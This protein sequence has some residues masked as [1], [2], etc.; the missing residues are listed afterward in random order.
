MSREPFWT[1]FS[2]FLKI[3]KLVRFFFL[4]FQSQQNST[5]ITCEYGG[6]FV[7]HCCRCENMTDVHFQHVAQR[8]SQE[9]GETMDYEGTNVTRRRGIC[10]F[11]PCELWCMRRVTT[12]WLSNSLY[13]RKWEWDMHRAKVAY[14]V[15][16][17]FSFSASSTIFSH[18]LW[19]IVSRARLSS[20]VMSH[21]HWT[22]AALG[23]FAT[24]KRS[25]FSFASMN[26]KFGLNQRNHSACC[27]S[28]PN[29]SL[30]FFSD[31]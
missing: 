20:T 17:F 7:K 24:R 6:T 11:P 27:F 4:M 26:R 31:F 14:S 15:F 12:P 5:Q 22:A 19:W 1:S 25:I 9:K 23:P 29:C 2:F 8:L 21:R 13:V 30:E 16:F 18:I 3:Q 10:I 28:V